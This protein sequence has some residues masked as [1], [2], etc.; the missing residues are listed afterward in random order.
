[1]NLCPSIARAAPIAVACVN[2][3]C[4][5]AGNA[6]ARPTRDWTPQCAARL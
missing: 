2:A 6:G 4:H 5:V 3:I 1:M